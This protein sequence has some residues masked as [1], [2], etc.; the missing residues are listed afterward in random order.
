MQAGSGHHA[1]CIPTRLL[2]EFNKEKIIKHV[3]P[4]VHEF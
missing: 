4:I 2:L 3:N 1:C